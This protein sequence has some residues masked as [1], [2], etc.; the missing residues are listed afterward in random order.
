MLFTADTKIAAEQDRKA[1]LQQLMMVRLRVKNIDFET[2]LP[3][4]GQR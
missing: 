1:V 3:E 4:A 2:L